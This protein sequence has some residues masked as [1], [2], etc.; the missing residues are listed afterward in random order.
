MSDITPNPAP[1]AVPEVPPTELPATGETPDTGT[2]VDWKAESDKFKALAKNWEARAKG[3]T[4]KAKAFDEFQE[5]Q[6]TE[7]QRLADRATAAEAKVAEMEARTLRAEVAAAK[8]IPVTLLS[9]TTQ[10]ELEASADALIAF[11]GEKPKPDFGGGD[12]G[13]DVGAKGAQLTRGALSSMTPDEINQARID[14]RLNDLL[15]IKPNI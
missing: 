12:R 11:R 3:N 7:Q 5:S 6:K 10:V 2:E 1:P 15:G 14:G 9:G 4:E 8:G 13:S